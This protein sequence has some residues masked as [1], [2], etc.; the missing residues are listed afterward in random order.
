VGQPIV[1]ENRGGATG[2]IGSAQAARSK[3]DGYTVV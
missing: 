2:T 3:P 1:V